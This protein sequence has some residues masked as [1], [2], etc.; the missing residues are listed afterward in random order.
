MKN[1]L[2]ENPHKPPRGR[3]KYTLSKFVDLQD[4]QSKTILDIGCG[5]GWFEVY[6]LKNKAKKMYG[7]EV[8]EQDLVTARKHVK[9]PKVR[10]EV[11]S[12]IEIPYKD[13]QFDT[14]VSWEVLEHIPKGTEIQMFKEV[15]RVL[16]P[17][18]VFYFSTPY[19][20]IPAK[21]FDPAWWLIGHRHYTQEDISSYAKKAGLNIEQFV[22]RGNW[23]HIGAILNL[24]FTKWMLRGPG[25]FDK[26]ILKKD[27]KSYTQDGFVNI[28]CKLSKQ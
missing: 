18:G 13:N 9:N 8:S 25:P 15:Y 23:W 6:G 10:F 16:K 24:Y 5:Y 2:N 4:I 26:L 27:E 1:I 19:A 11:G 7:N 22:V 17:G 20:S 12:A 28:F 14:V 3:L 21:M